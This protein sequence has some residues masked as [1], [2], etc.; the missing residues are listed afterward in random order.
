[1]FVASWDAKT[2]AQVQISRYCN[3]LAA[4]LRGLAKDGW[5]AKTA[6]FLADLKA[7]GESKTI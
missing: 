1:M 2:L 4:V 7:A 5:E 6:C 3:M